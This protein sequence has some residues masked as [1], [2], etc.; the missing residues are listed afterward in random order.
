MLVHADQPLPDQL[1]L[2]LATVSQF[3]HE[4]FVGFRLLILN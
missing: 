3:F 4:A 1:I 2:H